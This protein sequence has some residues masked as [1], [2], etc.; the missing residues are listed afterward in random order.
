MMSATDDKPSMLDH[1]SDIGAIVH[2]V[3]RRSV[4][5]KIHLDNL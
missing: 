3:G 5:S 2:W 1:R 4:D